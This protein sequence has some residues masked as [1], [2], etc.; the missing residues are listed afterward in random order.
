MLIPKNKPLRDPK[1]HAS[2]KVEGEHVCII[3]GTL[4]P[5]F[6][7]IR[8]GFFATG[9]KPDDN[10][11]MPL[12]HD[13][14]LEQGKSEIQFWI[15]YFD[16]IPEHMRLRAIQEMAKPDEKTDIM[17]IIKQIARNYYQSWKTR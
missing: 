4:L 6:A 5:D 12:R 14:H 1:Y 9:M 11:V 16:K 8:H 17:E 2:F 13:L 7:H 10:L 3:S 15:K